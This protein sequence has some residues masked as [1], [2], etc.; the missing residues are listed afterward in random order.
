MPDSSRTPPASPVGMARPRPDRRILGVLGVIAALLVMTSGVLGYQMGRDAARDRLLRN[1]SQAGL[2]VTS[3]Q[4]VTAPDA[5][6]DRMSIMG[7]VLDA[8]GEALTDATITF[9]GGPA[10]EKPGFYSGNGSFAIR[11]MAQ[12][13]YALVVT[14]QGRRERI[15]LEIIKSQRHLVTELVRRENGSYLLGSGPQTGSVSLYVVLDGG[16]ARLSLAGDEAIGLNVHQV[17]HQGTPA[18]I[19]TERLGNYG[20]QTIEGLNVIAPGSRGTF[21]FAVE[22]PKPFPLQY[23]LSLQ[24]EDE[25]RPALPLQYRLMLDV[26]PMEKA[27]PDDFPL[28][29]EWMPAEAVALHDVWIAGYSTRF[30]TLHWSWPSRNDQ[31]DTKIGMQD[32][33]PQYRLRINVYETIPRIVKQGQRGLT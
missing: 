23:S 29:E 22:N 8:R 14:H 19:F 15:A 2:F 3:L 20:V 27:G 1:A 11:G 32:G 6:F 26:I 4:P 21:I 30:Y 31:R 7:T 16:A 10:G 17:W 25:N 12:G 5:G 18:H 33:R 28:G 9:R 24:H 13:R